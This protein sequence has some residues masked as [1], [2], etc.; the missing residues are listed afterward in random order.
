MA[1]G[2]RDVIAESLV[3]SLT[4]DCITA[5]SQSDPTLVSSIKAGKMIDDPTEDRGN[6]IRILYGDPRMRPMRWRDERAQMNLP[7]AIHQPQFFRQGG[8][9]EA[10]EVGGGIWWW[11]RFMLQI[12]SNYTQQ[13]YDQDAAREY[14]NT[15]IQRV[16][17][18]L[19]SNDITGSDNFGETVFDGGFSKTA[20]EEAFETGADQDWIWRSFIGVEVLTYVD[21]ASVS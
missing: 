14:A 2:I 21:L 6:H 5:V 8:G 18:S 13:N 17:Q 1:V 16:R 3:A 10:A 7:G 11:R 4:A 9:M 19:R 15:V 20:W 12:I